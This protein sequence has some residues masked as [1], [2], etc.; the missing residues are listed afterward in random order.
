MINVAAP[1]PETLFGRL[2]R[3]PLRILPRDATVPILQ[4]PLKGARWIVG[5]QRHAFWLGS[6][7]PAMQN[8]IAATLKPGDTFYDIGANVGFYSLL[9]ARLVVNGAVFAFEPLPSN[10]DFIRQHLALNQANNVNIFPV[11]L[12]NRTGASY[13]AVEKTGAMGHLD[14]TGNLTVRCLTLDNLVSEER[15]APPTCIKMDV[16]GEE[17]RALQGAAEC[18]RRFRPT[19]FL[20]TH[21]E[22]VHAECLELLSSWNY[23]TTIIDQTIG[24]RAELLAT[25][26][27]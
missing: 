26:L 6:Y 21:G 18:F 7:E 12:S 16:E 2:L 8:L 17:A 15:L 24:D 27:P 9:A 20:A 22:K 4:G 14:E 5:S 3:L 1:S 11:A 19:L 23:R 10:V 13:F 25:P